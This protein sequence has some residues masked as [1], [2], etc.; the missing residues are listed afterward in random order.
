MGQYTDAG[1]TPINPHQIVRAAARRRRLVGVHRRSP[2]RYVE[3]LPA[4]VAR[5]DLAAL[6][7]TYPLD[8]VTDAMD[9]LARGAVMKAVLVA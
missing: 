7:T 3:L 6:A 5:F 2:G 1:D 8:A 4:L 9:A